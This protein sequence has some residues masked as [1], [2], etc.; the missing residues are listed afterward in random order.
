MHDPD[1]QSSRPEELHNKE[2]TTDRM[3]IGQGSKQS[4]TTDTIKSTVKS[5]S[6]VPWKTETKEK[7]D[8]WRIHSNPTPPQPL[9][10]RSMEL[11]YLR[12]IES[13]DTFTPCTTLSSETLHVGSKSFEELDLMRRV[14][15][16]EGIGLELPD[17]EEKKNKAVLHP[18]SSESNLP[19]NRRMGTSEQLHQGQRKDRTSPKQSSLTAQLNSHQQQRHVNVL[20]N[21]AFYNSDMKHRQ[22]REQ[23][24]AA[25]SQPGI[26]KV[27]SFPGPKS[28]T[29][30]PPHPSYYEQP[31]SWAH[32]PR[33]QSQQWPISPYHRA[34][35]RQPGERRQAS[36]PL[37]SPAAA[38]SNHNQHAKNESYA[39][40]IQKS[41]Q[42]QSPPRSHY[43]QHQYQQ[44]RQHHSVNRP[45]SSS[46]PESRPMSYNQKFNPSHSN[47]SHSHSQNYRNAH[48]SHHSSSKS[49][50][51][52]SPHAR[53]H[54]T[55]SFPSSTG[56]ARPAPEVLKTLLRKK[57]CLYETGTSRAIALITWLVG[58][59]LALH[60]GYFSRQRLQ[61]GV[62]AVVAKKIDSGMITRTKV[63]R[64]MQ[65]IL[66]S[67]FHYIIPR[68]DGSEENGEAFRRTFQE[69]VADDTHL[70]KS[71]SGPWDGLDIKLA[72]DVIYGNISPSPSIEKNND[73]KKSQEEQKGGDA[74]RL[75]LLCFNEN[76]RSA[77]DVLRCH[78]DFI[79]DAAIS[80][81][82]HLSADEWRYFFSRKDDDGSQ[83]SASTNAI[84]SSFSGGFG[85]VSHNSPLIRG[86]DGCDIPYLSFD[87]PEEVSD[88]L[89]FKETVPEP[90]AKSADVLGQMNSN[91]LSKFRNTWCCKRYDHDEGLC[92]FAH[93]SVNKGWLRRDPTKYQYCEKMC[94]HVAV[95][96][97]SEG[98]ILNGVHINA[99]KH[100]MNCKFAHS[101]EEVDYH[102]KRYK[103]KVCEL[104]KGAS[105]CCHLQD[106]CPHS[107][108]NHPGHHHRPCRHGHGSSK[109][110]E[111]STN[112][113]SKGGHSHSHSHSGGGGH[114]HSSSS[115]RREEGTNAKIPDG[116]PVL[117]LNPAPT[118][119][120]EKSL[121]F[122]GL[123]DLYRRNCTMHYA[124]YLR[125]QGTTEYTMFDNNC[126][127]KE[128]LFNPERSHEDEFS[129]FRQ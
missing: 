66:N 23:S 54:H 129:L 58:R 37:G 74:K 125:L 9:E 116:A 62:H 3:I 43:L 4:N 16:G 49:M 57:A 26:A 40:K 107:H 18:G 50:I 30:R 110:H 10:Q 20:Q 35:H 60:D 112:P 51:P 92:R 8:I 82:L 80:A 106:I 13:V 31:Q 113:R 126:G 114:S 56:G 77:E 63:N 102:P 123:R 12:D 5:P 17:L 96:K 36:S 28:D 45:R 94:P 108:P 21:T 98:G 100:G 52:S 25:G 7:E 19:Y 38:R 61:S 127:L 34:I 48:P 95:I 42:I 65:I 83:T 46:N 90:W 24:H 70:L 27:P 73:E 59:K 53:I 75:V 32:H 84:E 121:Q 89:D 39:N 68:P 118:S 88:C 78:N 81:N 105:R 122:A 101:Q 29:Q 55:N 86:A 109:R 76:V 120:F 33:P 115:P 99:C 128:S 104:A 41:P 2:N 117:F 124:H 87:I 71:L 11:D 6:V 22:L 103:S 64:C 93:V 85:A 44:R 79:R 72:D 47:W 14:R 97:S 91:E 15:A 111:S 67:C 1:M 119:E 69:T